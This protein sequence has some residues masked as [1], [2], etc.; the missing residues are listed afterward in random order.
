M[1]FANVCAGF[2]RSCYGECCLWRFLEL[3]GFLLCIWGVLVLLVSL[4]FTRLGLHWCASHWTRPL[5][6]GRWWHYLCNLR[7][8]CLTA[9]ETAYRYFWFHGYFMKREPYMR[10]LVGLPSLHGYYACMV[11]WTNGALRRNCRQKQ[12]DETS[13]FSFMGFSF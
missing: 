7:G 5:G 10:A 11:Y 4:L 9:H 13:F 3:L 6:G 12:R 2:V 1:L 8:E